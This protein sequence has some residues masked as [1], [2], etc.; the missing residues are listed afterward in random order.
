MFLAMH[1]KN[2]ELTVKTSLFQ[3][4][5][6]S[7][8]V[9]TLNLTQILYE[10]LHNFSHKI[11]NSLLRITNEVLETHMRKL[12]FTNISRL[13]E[14]LEYYRK[15]PR[16]YPN[17][18]QSIWIHSWIWSSLRYFLDQRGEYVSNGLRDKQLRNEYKPT[19]IGVLFTSLRL[20]PLDVCSFYRFKIGS[21]KIFKIFFSDS[22]KTKKPLSTPIILL[23][24]QWRCLV[25]SPTPTDL[26][27]D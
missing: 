17:M 10:M 6:T 3:W 24:I 19:K 15:S 23:Q 7:D 8:Q 20:Q 13:V 22:G 18:S 26:I 1:Q 11:A 5:A 2:A 4:L 21:A 14:P 12:K 27:P 16:G 9:D 25:C